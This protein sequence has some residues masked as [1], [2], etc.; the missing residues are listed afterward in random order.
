MRLDELSVSSIVR[1]ENDALERQ[2]KI[3]AQPGTYT[4]IAYTF[5]DSTQFMNARSLSK[6]VS[7]CM[8][9]MRVLLKY[10][11]GNL[12]KATLKLS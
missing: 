10:G 2:G 6:R 4:S 3:S 5:C 9:V 11:A 7:T 12:S 1:L 8:A